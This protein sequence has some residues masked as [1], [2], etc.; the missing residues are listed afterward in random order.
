V[1]S[2]ELMVRREEAL[3]LVVKT[4]GKLAAEEDALDATDDR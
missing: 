4:L 2:D 1:D 3:S